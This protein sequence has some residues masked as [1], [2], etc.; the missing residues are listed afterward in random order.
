MFRVLLSSSAIAVSALIAQPALA[1][2]AG[3]SFDGP[4]VSGAVSLD[5]SANNARRLRFDTNQD[6]TFD[7]DVRTTG[8]VFAF[9]NGFCRGAAT[10]NVPSTGCVS[11][12]DDLGFAL[13]VG[14]DWRFGGGPLVGGVLLEGSTTNAEDYTSGFS[15][16]PASYTTSRELDYS[17]AARTRAGF[18]PG[19]GR[20]LFYIT[21]GVAYARIKHGFETTNTV[22]SFTIVNDDKMRF[23]VQAGAG[24]EI[25]LAPGFSLG[26]E[27]LYSRYDDDSSYVAVGKGTAGATNPFLLVSG[28]TNLRPSYTNLD[29]QSF[30][31]TASYHF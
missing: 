17:I 15:T 3:P 27:Y 16:T 12:D 4:Y 10:S 28:G 18:S 23:G 26:L 29:L 31:A 30:R 21:G 9:S 19:D 5:S 24:A 2:D 13:R 22:N 8:G 11:D 7:D 6:G 14:Y 25:M 1:Q 20:G